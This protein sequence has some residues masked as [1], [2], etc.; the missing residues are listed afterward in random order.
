[1]KI[2]NYSTVLSFYRGCDSLQSIVVKEQKGF[3]RNEKQ[4]T[5]YHKFSRIKSFKCRGAGKFPH[6]RGDKLW[7]LIAGNLW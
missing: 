1:M 2:E 6:R 5:N 7:V 3:H 4:A